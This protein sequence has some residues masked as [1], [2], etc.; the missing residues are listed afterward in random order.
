MTPKTTLLKTIVFLSSISLM[1]SCA[2]NKNTNTDQLASMSKATITGRISAKLV[3]TVGAAA[4]QYTTGGQVITAWVDTKD[5]VIASGPADTNA[6]YAKKYFT[7]TSDA[8]GYYSL[9]IDV[10][11]YKAATVHI[12]A[13]DF[14]YNVLMKKAGTPPTYYTDRHVFKSAAIAPIVINN[15]QKVI[16]DIAYN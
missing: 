16:T 14:E 3:D 13:S 11:S 7:A 15:G 4:T 5:Y 10:S 6:V 8:N 9:S 1:Y 2:K 12:V